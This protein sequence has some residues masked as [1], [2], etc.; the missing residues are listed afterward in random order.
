MPTSQ[1]PSDNLCKN[2]KNDQIT[3]GIYYL[4]LKYILNIICDFKRN[5][6][7]T[8]SSKYLKDTFYIN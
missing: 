4:V 8:S 1:I 5:F 7:T 2:T 3:E 6:W